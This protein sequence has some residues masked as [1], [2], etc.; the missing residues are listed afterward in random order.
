MK[1]TAMEE[2][3]N[4]AQEQKDYG[5]A[6]TTA[7]FERAISKATELLKMEQEQ[8]IEAVSEGCYEESSTQIDGD[9]FFKKTYR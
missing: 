6:H 1:N 3:I 7:D 2:F 8:I 4:W 5:D 9:E